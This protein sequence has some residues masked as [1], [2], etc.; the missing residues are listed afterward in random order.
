MT[1]R[2]ERYRKAPT[3]LAEKMLLTIAHGC[4]QSLIFFDRYIVA[5]F[6]ENVPFEVL[7]PYF[8]GPLAICSRLLTIAH[9]L[10]ARVHTCQKICFL[11]RCLHVHV[12]PAV[13]TAGRSRLAIL[14]ELSKPGLRR[15][16]KNDMMEQR[17]FKVQQALFFNALA[18]YG[19]DVA[20]PLAK[21][22]QTCNIILYIYTCLY[23]VV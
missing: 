10:C 22:H 19:H 18:I 6:A 5:I 16:T 3:F 13:Q 23:M 7:G 17:R 20:I 11:T 21:Q 14:L 8:L 12:C 15:G 1:P 4:S 2:N 9:D